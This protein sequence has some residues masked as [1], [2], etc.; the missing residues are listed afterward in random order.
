[1]P[2]LIF[3]H[4]NR[5]ID[6]FL[7]L[8][9]ITQYSKDI[10]SVTFVANAFPSLFTL[11]LEYSIFATLMESFQTLFWGTCSN[12]YKS[13]GIISSFISLGKHTRIFKENQ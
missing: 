1:M 11:D 10:I 9:N 2:V 5:F 12:K 6:F 7:L 4:F 13:V 3:A 8:C